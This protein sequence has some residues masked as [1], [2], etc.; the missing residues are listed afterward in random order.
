M[1]VRKHNPPGKKSLALL[2]ALPL[3]VFA[4][5]ASWIFWAETHPDLERDLRVTAQAQL[6]EWLPEV[7]SPEPGTI[8]FSPASED[9]SGPE[10]D[11][12]L[13]HGLDEPGGIWDEMAAA[14]AEAGLTAWEFRYPNDQ[15]ID[16]SADLLAE[17]WPTLETETVFLVGHSMGGLVIRDF[18]SRHRHPVEGPPAVGGATV[19]GVIMIG[20]PNQG[21]EWARL[22]A[23]LEIREWMADLP[24]GRA[25]LF[26]GLRDGTGAAKIDLRPGSRF[27][28]ELNARAWPDAVPMLI[29]GGQLTEPTPEMLVGLRRL[30]DDLGIDDFDQVVEKWWRDAGEGVG[31]GA[32]SVESLAV[33]G[34]PEP[35]L[36]PASHRGLLLTMP[37][38]E[39]QPPAI[40]AVVEQLRD[41]RSA[42]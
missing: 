38:S 22:R 1:T 35:V 18:V 33:P 8:G 13:I 11:V 23:W 9:H 3:V 25:S 30:A 37:L 6:E 19:G 41:W 32:V 5:V 42:N 31:D 10:P 36:L 2:L 15:A 7:V 12:V 40:E 27:L 39:Q 20:T 34:G 29:L 14:M 21:S 28:S 4:L 16:H 24:E 26:A 17:Q